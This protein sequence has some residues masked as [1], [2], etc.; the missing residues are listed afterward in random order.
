MHSV[1]HLHTIIRS[2]SGNFFALSFPGAFEHCYQSPA[3][4][5]CGCI[6]RPFFQLNFSLNAFSLRSSASSECL[7]FEIRLSCTC[8]VYMQ[9]AHSLD[10]NCCISNMS[11]TQHTH[12]LYT[13]TNFYFW[14]VSRGC[15]SSCAKVI[16]RSYF[17]QTLWQQS[18]SHTNTHTHP[19]TCKITCKHWLKHI[20]TSPSWPHNHTPT[21]ES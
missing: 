20:S 12:T 6:I 9:L 10:T 15:D 16:I 4:N 13:C 5:N 17:P 21:N 18:Q 2:H 3:D 11:F 1:A 8:S 19:I 14:S 7:Y